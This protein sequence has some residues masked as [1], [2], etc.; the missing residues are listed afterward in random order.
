MI[1]EDERIDDLQLKGYKI[2]QKKDGF[3]FGMDAVLVANYLKTKRNDIVV[4]LGTGTGIIPLIVNAK[5]DLKKI[6]AIEIQKEMAEM[7]ERTIKLNRL[8]DKIEVINIDLKDSL[9]YLDKNRIDIVV[10]NPPYM[11]IGEGLVNETD[12]KKVSRHEIKCN[13]DDICRV[14]SA[15][16]RHNG[17]FFMVHRPSRLADIITNLRKY[18]L[19][20]KEMRFVYPKIERESNLVLIKAIKAARPELRLLKPLIVYNQKGDYTDEIREIYGLDY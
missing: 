20:P 17:H 6:Y 13:I 8:E 19:E 11:S 15:L 3:C 4:D 9:E 18:K 12:M 10:S 14:A 5:N 1:K 2:I 16:L 7:T